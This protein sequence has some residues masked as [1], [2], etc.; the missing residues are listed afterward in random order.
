[1]FAADQLLNHGHP[2]CRPAPQ[3]GSQVE[4]AP[5]SRFAGI[6]FYLDSVT[7]LRYE[8]FEPVASPGFAQPHS[9]ICTRH[10]LRRCRVTLRASCS[11]LRTAQRIRT[12]FSQ[13]RL[14][15]GGREAWDALTAQSQKV[16]GARGRDQERRS[17]GPPPRRGDA[18]NGIRRPRRSLPD[19][20]L[21]KRN[22]IFIGI[23]LAYALGVALPDVPAARRHR[24]ALS[25][26]GRGVAGRDGAADGGA[27]RA[28]VARRRAAGRNARA[29]VPH[30]STRAASRPTSTASRRR[31]SSCARR[32]STAGARSCSIR[33]AAPSSAPTTRAGTTSS[34][35]SRASYGARTTADI[36]GDPR[37]S[38]MYVAVPIHDLSPAGGGEIIGAVSVGKPV[39]SFGQFVEAARK[40]DAAARRDLGGR[41]A[42]AGRHPVGLAGAA[43]RRASPTTCATCARSARSA[44]RASA[45]ARSARS[46][47]PTTRCATRSPAATTSPTT[48]RR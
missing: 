39:Q 1:M 12:M 28:R 7:T 33:A 47:P 6:G 43:V 21:T 24:P 40:Q 37:T 13:H 35:R 31:A 25:R 5:S 26:V 32:S 9:P 34:S 38:V 14:E 41:G 8:G 27:D 36:E 23:L 11:S 22:R 18:P 15:G 2:R 46:A 45:G 29:G 42:A 17:P 4:E 44:C 10:Q 48:C 19:R 3:R 30:R 20:A 16:D